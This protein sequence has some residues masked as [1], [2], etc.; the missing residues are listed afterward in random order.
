MATIYSKK[1][2]GRNREI[3]FQIASGQTDSDTIKLNGRTPIG[4]LVPAAPTGT[5]F[6]FKASLDSDGTNF[7]TLKDM[8]GTAL[9]ITTSQAFFK[10]PPADFDGVELL[11]VI[12]SSSEGSARTLTLIVAD[13]KQ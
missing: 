10:L 7:Y 5:S 3:Q 2:V 12:S 8:T 11:K 9:T 1:P 6:T 4:L 13:Y